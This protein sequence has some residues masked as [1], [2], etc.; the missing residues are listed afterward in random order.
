MRACVCACA[1]VSVCTR[2]CVYM[3]VCACVCTFA[4]LREHVRAYVR[5]GYVCVGVFVCVHV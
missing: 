3:R 1:Y 4:R 5:W 2:A